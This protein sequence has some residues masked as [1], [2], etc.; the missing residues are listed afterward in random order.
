MTWQHYLGERKEMM[1]ISSILERFKVC[2]RPSSVVVVV[3]VRTIH[4]YEFRVVKVI[5]YVQQAAAY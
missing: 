5:A 2:R 3:V 1:S 4:T